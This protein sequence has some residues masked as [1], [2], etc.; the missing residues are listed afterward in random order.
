MFASTLTGVVSTRAG[1]TGTVGK[2]GAICVNCGSTAEDA[3]SAGD[4]ITGVA[5]QT[6]SIVEVGCFAQ[7]I[8]L[9]TF[10]VEVK[11]KSS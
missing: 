6:G 11:E 1:N 3:H 5:A 8:Y 4:G 7:R 2:F 10:S 9:F